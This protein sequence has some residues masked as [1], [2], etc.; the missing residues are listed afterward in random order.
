MLTSY[1]RSLTGWAMR[2]RSSRGHISSRSERLKHDGS[3]S[4]GRR[5]EWNDV[6]FL[7]VVSALIIKSL[8]SCLLIM[9]GCRAD[10]RSLPEKRINS[11]KY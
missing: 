11:T 2:A 4:E 8:S 3:R 7:L 10:T 9:C 6:V 5:N 1:A